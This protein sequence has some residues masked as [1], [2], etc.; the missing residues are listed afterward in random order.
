MGDEA[1]NLDVEKEEQYDDVDHDDDDPA[2]SST[3]VDE[4][5]KPSDEDHGADSTG[6][7]CSLTVVVV[8]SIVILAIALGSYFGVEK[9]RANKEA[10]SEEAT[11]PGSGDGT[12]VSQYGGSERRGTIKIILWTD[13]LYHVF[14]TVLCLQTSSFADN[15]FTSKAFQ[16]ENFDF[17]VAPSQNF[18]LFATGG[19]TRNNPIPA[20]YAYWGADSVLRLAAKEQIKTILEELSNGTLVVDEATKNVASYYTAALDV[21]AVDAAGIDPLNPILE[22]IDYIVSNY[23]AGDGETYARLLGEIDGIWGLTPFFVLDANPDQMMP[24]HSVPYIYQDGIGLPDREYY[25]NEDE[26]GQAIIT[27]YIDHMAKMF[28]LLEMNQTDE[29][30]LF[31]EAATL[32]YNTEKALAEAHLKREDINNPY[33]IYN[34]LSVESISNFSDSNFSYADYLAGATNRTAEDLGNILVMTTE[35]LYRSG[36]VFTTIDPITLEYFLK[37]KMLYSYSK[38]LPTPFVEQD[39]SFFGTTLR[40]VTENKPRWERAVDFTENVLGEALG[41]IYVQRH[42]DEES[43]EKVSAMVTNLLISMKEMIEE[44]DWIQSESTRNEALSKLS[45]FNV[46]I[47]Y[48]DKWLDYSSL[49]FEDGEVLVSMQ[50]KAK[51]FLFQQKISEMNAPTDPDKWYMTPQT[52][53]AYYNPVLNEIVFPAAILQFPFFDKEID[54]AVNYGGIGAVIGH[55]V[56]YGSVHYLQSRSS[57]CWWYSLTDASPNVLCR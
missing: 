27:K 9:A 22:M 11:V 26:S 50:I 8:I 12:Y 25:F 43:K 3:K 13:V 48:P 47:G 44:I 15:N 35:A 14:F 36:Q 41:K 19:W 40:G 24:N 45:T 29:S 52:V 16:S 38:Y 55:E 33:L 31:V 5:M 28:A 2:A 46:K 7:R 18:F 4:M 53:N 21:A 23:T 51:R 37:W 57:N 20:G 34:M 42:F 39:F 56:R 17:D 30:Q 32:V 1:N 49:R 10:T 54:D 6:N